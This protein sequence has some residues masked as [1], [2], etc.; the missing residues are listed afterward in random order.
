MSRCMLPLHGQN[1]VMSM[2]LTDGQG[3]IP[4]SLILA[5]YIY[6]Q[7]ETPSTRETTMSNDIIKA[8]KQDIASAEDRQDW[9]EVYRL[10]R[11]LAKMQ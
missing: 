6:T 3:T 5:Y 11:L 7:D 10:M 1:S 2:V 8:I 9:R 4:F